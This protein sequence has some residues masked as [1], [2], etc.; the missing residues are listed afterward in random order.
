MDLGVQKHGFTS[1]PAPLVPSVHRVRCP[2]APRD[3]APF[4]HALPGVPGLQDLGRHVSLCAY[5]LRLVAQGRSG[6]ERHC[7]RIAVLRG[8][9]GARD[10][11]ARLPVTPGHRHRFRTGTPHGPGGAGRLESPLLSKTGHGPDRSCSHLR[12]GPRGNSLLDTVGR[13]RRRIRPL[14]AKAHRLGAPCDTGVG[15]V[16][17]QPGAGPRHPADGIHADCAQGRPFCLCLPRGVGGDGGRLCRLGLCAAEG[18][19]RRRHRPEALPRG[20]RGGAHRIP[21]PTVPRLC[22]RLS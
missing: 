22:G 13:P 14:L 11:D 17:H 8:L 5:P 10:C 7:G 18:A 4:R 9:S 21:M 3:A 1:V 2:P 16:P 19:L 12:A 6:E 15:M 20:R